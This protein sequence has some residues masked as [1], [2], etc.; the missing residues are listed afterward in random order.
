MS[1]F[2]FRVWIIGK[3]FMKTIHG[4]GF[5]CP[6]KEVFLNNY[7]FLKYGTKSMKTPK[8]LEHRFKRQIVFD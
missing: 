1:D 7:D 3:T 2:G 5:T 6:K 4:I 8:H